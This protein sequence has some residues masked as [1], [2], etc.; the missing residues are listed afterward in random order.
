MQKLTPR[1]GAELSSRFRVLYYRQARD[2][3][4]FAA[5]AV[6]HYNTYPS[7]DWSE[8]NEMAWTFYEAVEDEEQLAIA[9][10]WAEES[11]KLNESYY[12]Y[13]TL[14]WLYFKIGKN[15]K[16]KKAANKAI[17]LGEAAG[18]DV[19]YTKDLLEKL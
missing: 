11:I 9:V 1:K 7:E 6:A 4:K 14:A 12:N 8:L 10:K 2:V 13:D 19:S 18:E 5:A 15:G 16:A 3:E 17:E